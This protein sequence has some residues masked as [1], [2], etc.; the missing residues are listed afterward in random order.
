MAFLRASLVLV[1]ILISAAV[2]AKPGPWELVTNEKGVKVQARDIP[3]Q[4]LRCVSTRSVQSS[5]AA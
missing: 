5:G 2:H 3:G 4:G 1:L